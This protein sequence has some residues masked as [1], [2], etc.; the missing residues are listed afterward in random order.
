M[1][2]NTASRYNRLIFEKKLM[3]LSERIDNHLYPLVLGILQ[4]YRVDLVKKLY[5]KF[6]DVNNPFLLSVRFIL[7]F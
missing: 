2:S 4:D 3:E 5:L 7:N 6:E 1:F